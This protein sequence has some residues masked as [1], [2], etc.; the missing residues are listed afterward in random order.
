M[1]LEETLDQYFKEEE[2]IKKDRTYVIPSSHQSISPITLDIKGT[3]LF[4]NAEIFIKKAIDLFTIND[5]NF[6]TTYGN[7]DY[8]IEHQKLY[9]RVS[10]D[11]T[12]RPLSKA[13][14]DHMFYALLNDTKLL[15]DYL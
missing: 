2:V 4:M 11:V 6:M 5:L 8:D 10:L 14:L 7:F 3:S 15:K 9:Y 13:M 12:D 1:Q